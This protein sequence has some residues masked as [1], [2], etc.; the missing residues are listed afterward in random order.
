MLFPKGLD[1]I[2]NTNIKDLENW[3]EDDSQ[4]GTLGH[5]DRFPG[6]SLCSYILELKME[7]PATLK[8]QRKQTTK[9]SNKS[10]S[11]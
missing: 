10:C 3:A 11:L 7:E 4:L 1:V 2:Y 8:C 6:F 5:S 9:K